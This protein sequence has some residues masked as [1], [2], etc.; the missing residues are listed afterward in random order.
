VPR[1]SRRRTAAL[2][3][4]VGV[5][6]ASTAALSAPP[7]GALPTTPAKLADKPVTKS[8]AVLDPRGKK[9]GT[10]KWTVTT[11]GGNCCE[12]LVAATRS[13]R[14][15]EFG[16]QFPVYSDDK[17][18]TWTE[19]RTLVPA[20]GQLDDASPRQV[21]GGEGTI[22]MAPGGDI[23]GVGWDPYSGDRLQSFLYDAETKTWSYAEAPLHE[24]FYDRQWMAVAKGPFTIGGQTYPWVSMVLSNFNRRVVLI[25]TDGLNYVR[26][27]R[28]DVEALAGGT[29]SAFPVKGDPDLDYMQEHAETRITPLPGGG[30]LSLNA[31]GT[32]GCERQVLQRD[33]T[34]ACLGGDGSVEFL[35]AVHSDSRGWLHDV[36]VE[37]DE[38][39]YRISRDG[40]RSWTT[41]LLRIPG[42]ANVES[43][44]FKAHG[45]LGLSAVAVHALK[46]DGN[47]QD[48]VLRIDTKKGRAVHRDTLL[49]GAGDMEFTAGLDVSGVVSG[50]KSNRVD[51]ATVA[52][53]PNG[54][55]AAGFADKT[56]DDPAVAVLQ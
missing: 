33:A 1:S 26:P 13:G 48:M 23:V 45:K 49:V 38:V 18:K 28:A 15:V 47:H 41:S 34:W 10:K 8:Y 12:V 14:L 22:V 21:G 36:T 43:W 6:A 3:V 4:G 37:G 56:Y 35:G 39:T 17:G 20:T 55:I 46:D 7:P 31:V 32:T 54:T 2:L 29:V 53:L 9:T 11:A 52:I 30:A 51:F 5:V 25:S 40:G 16:G 44:D 42:E 24:P 19:I 27:S 50:A